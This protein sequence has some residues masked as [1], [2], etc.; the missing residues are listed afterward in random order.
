M[1]IKNLK[2]LAESGRMDREPRLGNASF[3]AASLTSA[4]SAAARRRRPSAAARPRGGASAP[5]KRRGRA[6]TVHRE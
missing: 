5:A 2:N 3:P 4:T 6:P 1:K